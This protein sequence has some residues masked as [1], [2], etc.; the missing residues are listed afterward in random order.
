MVT[1]NA[2]VAG[3][4]ASRRVDQKQLFALGQE[5]QQSISH[6]KSFDE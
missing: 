6:E 3:M 2:A 1:R 4:N 5:N